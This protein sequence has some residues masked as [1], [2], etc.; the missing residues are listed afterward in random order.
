MRHK[1]ALSVVLVGLL[2]LWPIAAPAG[3]QTEQ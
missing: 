3:A 1:N 2:S